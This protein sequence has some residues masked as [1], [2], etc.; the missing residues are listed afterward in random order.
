M[1]RWD[2]YSDSAR[3]YNVEQSENWQS[4]G[5]LAARLVRK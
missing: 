3:F 1:S 2:E 5:E 4:I